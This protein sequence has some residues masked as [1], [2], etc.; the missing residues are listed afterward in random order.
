MKKS[1]ARLH[2]GKKKV[3]LVSM[4]INN[5]HIFFHSHADIWEIDC[6]FYSGN[7]FLFRYHIIGEQ[8]QYI[9]IFFIPIKHFSPLFKRRLYQ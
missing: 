3:N 2:D 8:K 7:S 1:T 9:S 6:I 4:N 5:V